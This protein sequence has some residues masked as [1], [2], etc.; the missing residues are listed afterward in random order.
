MKRESDADLSAT[1]RCAEMLAACE[2]AW[3][4]GLRLAVADA[5]EICRL[6]RQAP[7]DWLADAVATTITQSMT[8]IEKRRRHED[9]KHYTRWDAV[10]ELRQRRHELLQLSRSVPLPGGHFVDDDRGSTWE[11]CFIAVSKL[12]EGTEA[13]GSEA[14][15]KASYQYVKHE[16]EVGR[17]DR[18]LLV[19]PR[20]DA[21]SDPLTFTRKL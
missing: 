10:A 2:K 18:F 6:Y 3:R 1:R 11:K 12:L 16:I 9:M 7:P 4:S 17:G 21:T 8:K 14:T 20:I 13:A 19:D 15:I 5:V